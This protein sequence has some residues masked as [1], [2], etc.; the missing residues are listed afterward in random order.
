MKCPYCSA[1]NSTHVISTTPDQ[2]GGIRRRRECT[3]CGRRFSTFERLIADVPQVI[4]A[5]GY[6]EEFDRDKMLRSVRIA[7]VK[8]PV[9]AEDL[10]R[11]A[12]QIED[13]LRRMSLLEVPSQIVGDLVME[14]LKELDLIAYI[15]FAIVY[16]NLDS[17]PAIQS[18]IEKLM[19]VQK[20]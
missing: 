18:E 13:A 14:G 11:L 4:K 12:D 16:L 8:R 9:S 1:L 6:R 3:N 2:M 19:Q 7:C 10:E 20:T 17:L 5:G 15:R